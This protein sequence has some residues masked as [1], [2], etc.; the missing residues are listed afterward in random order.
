M[1]VQRL[2]VA[3]GGLSLVEVL[4]ALCIASVAMAAVAHSAGSTI[5]A[6]RKA[7]LRQAA[8]ALAEIAMEDTL[9]VGALDLGPVDQTESVDD[10]ATRFTR[11]IVVRRG[12]EDDLWLISVSV[13]AP[14]STTLAELRT[15]LRRPWGDPE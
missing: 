9:A 6:R 4:I 14:P 2:P 12:P 8:A 1:R 7:D 3:A 5:F 15:L 11:R 10:S 13:A